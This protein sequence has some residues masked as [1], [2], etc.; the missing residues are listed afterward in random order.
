MSSSLYKAFIYMP[1]QLCCAPERNF[2]PFSRTPCNHIIVLARIMA[3]NKPDC[4]LLLQMT[5]LQRFSCQEMVTGRPCIR[6]LI[7]N[8]NA[9]AGQV[10][11][12]IMNRLSSLHKKCLLCRHKQTVAAIC[13]LLAHLSRH[14]Y[15]KGHQVCFSEV[16]M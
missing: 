16:S 15:Y 6:N 2:C 11:K 5:T 8:Q 7:S 10:G 1:L 12:R 9:F 4:Q 13:S 14:N 3:H